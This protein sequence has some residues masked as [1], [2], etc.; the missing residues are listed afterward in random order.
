MPPPSPSGRHRASACITRWAAAARSASTA[1]R[2]RSAAR[3]AS[4]NNGSRRPSSASRTC[5]FWD[6]PDSQIFDTPELRAKIAEAISELAP[7]VV[8]TLYSG[9]E[10]APGAPNQRDHIE[11][12]NAGCGRCTI[13]C[14][15]S[16]VGSSS[17]AHVA[18]TAKRWTISSRS[19]VDSLAAHDVYLSVLQPRRAG[20]RAGARSVDV[21]TLPP[22]PGIRGPPLGGVHP[23]AGELSLIAPPR[24]P[25]RGRR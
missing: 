20:A 15:T 25:A 8:I 6:F 9:P 17:M 11:F 18:R 12:S 1:C 22:L 4:V 16:R 2:P 5:E 24:G 10:W 7:D 3:C 14:R 13:R 19:A 21:T 23:Q